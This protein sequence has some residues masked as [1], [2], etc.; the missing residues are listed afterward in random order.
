MDL[1]NIERL[2]I[3]QASKKLDRLYSSFESLIDDLRNRDLPDEIINSINEKINS[4]NSSAREKKILIS[5][6]SKS[7]YTILNLLEKE[8]KL[9][10]RNHY[11]KKWLVLGMAA[12]GM[13]LGA[14]IGAARGD[15]SFLGIGIPL[16]MVI[17]IGVGTAMDRRAKDKG[18]QLDIEM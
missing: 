18:K 12:F 7:I 2:E 4:I 16:G 13:P 1:I 14:A 17:G 9:V 10:P 8:L 6:L 3:P 15:M 11:Q 5:I